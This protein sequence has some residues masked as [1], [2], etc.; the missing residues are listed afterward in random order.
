M[1]VA[2]GRVEPEVKYLVEY[3]DAY[4]RGVMHPRNRN[5]ILRCAEILGRLKIS[6]DDLRT[7]TAWVRQSVERDFK[8][9][10][11]NDPDRVFKF[12]CEVELENF[13]E[14]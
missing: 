6:Y 13:S 3:N 10:G 12:L 11:D 2:S 5:A 1:W 4:S 8:N 7:C 9:C 14:S